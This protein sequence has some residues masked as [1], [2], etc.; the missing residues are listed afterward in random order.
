MD[1]AVTIL[2]QSRRLSRRGAPQRGHSRDARGR[3]SA[4]STSSLCPIRRGTRSGFGPHAAT[5]A[6]SPSD[7]PSLL[8]LHTAGTVKLL[9]SPRQSRGVSYLTKKTQPVPYGFGNRHSRPSIRHHLE[10]LV[11]TP[12]QT[13]LCGVSRTLLQWSPSRISS[14]CMTDFFGA[15]QRSSPGKS[16]GSEPGNCMVPHRVLFTC[17]VNVSESRPL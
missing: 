14:R 6:L 9:L 8:R 15:A 4:Y 7:E 10:I 13:V 17:D 12:P 16:G 3:R 5:G 1:P 2:R 11:T